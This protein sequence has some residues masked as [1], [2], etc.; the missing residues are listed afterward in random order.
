MQDKT[1]DAEIVLNTVAN[2][3]GL[4]KSAQSQ[5]DAAEEQLKINA[6]LDFNQA[7]EDV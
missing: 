6:L 3:E 2:A 1:K 5:I 7:K 4:I